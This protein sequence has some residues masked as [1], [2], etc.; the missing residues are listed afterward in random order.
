MV[1]KSCC[2]HV[3][4][5]ATQKMLVKCGAK[6]GA[7][8]AGKV[9]DFRTGVHATASVSTVGLVAGVAVGANR[10]FEGYIYAHSIYQLKRK[11]TFKM[12]SEREYKVE[13]ARQGLI[14]GGAAVGGIVGAIAG[15]VVIPVPIL[16]AAVGGMI[17]S[18]IGQMA[19]RAEGAALAS[20]FMS[21]EDIN[22]LPEI[23]QNSFVS[24]CDLEKL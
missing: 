6:A 5:D 12:I 10:L 4:A 15:Q 2:Q 22:T 11:K 21:E 3:V 20:K 17:G 16:G 14:N 24:I 18:V 9:M 8:A 13:V 1:R 7:K 23:V 19:G